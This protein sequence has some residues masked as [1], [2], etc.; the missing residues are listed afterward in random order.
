M[1]LQFLIPVQKKITFRNWYQLRI[2]FS[3]KLNNLISN[4]KMWNDI[5]F[6]RYLFMPLKTD[7]HE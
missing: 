2:F 3:T 7:N 5:E 1:K 4:E 6:E